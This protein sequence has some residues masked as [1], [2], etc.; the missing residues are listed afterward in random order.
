ML[1]PSTVGQR[2]WGAQQEK[3]ATL[4]PFGQVLQGERAR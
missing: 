2:R 3:Q 4:G 1:R